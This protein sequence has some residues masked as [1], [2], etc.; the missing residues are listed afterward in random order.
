[1]FFLFPLSLNLPLKPG[2]AALTKE[3]IKTKEKELLLRCSFRFPYNQQ[4]ITCNDRAP[5][6]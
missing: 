3:K 5:K 6:E 1:M 4:P 2:A